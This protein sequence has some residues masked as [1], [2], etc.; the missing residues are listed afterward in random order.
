[1]AQRLKD[2]GLPEETENSIKQKLKHGTFPATFLLATLAAL[3]KDNL[4]LEDV[5]RPAHEALGQSRDHS[6]DYGWHCA[7]PLCRGGLSY[8][9]EHCGEIP[10]QRASGPK[11]KPQAPIFAQTGEDRGDEEDE[12]NKRYPVACG[13]IGFGPSVIGYLDHHEGFF[14]GIFTAALFFATFF[15]WRSTRD[16]TALTLE[17]SKL[18]REEFIASHRPRI[19]VRHIWIRDSLQED[20][21]ITA[22]LVF[23]NVGDTTALITSVTC[24]FKIVRIGDPLPEKIAALEGVWKLT[25]PDELDPG[26]AMTIAQISSSEVFSKQDIQNIRG[27]TVGLFCFGRICYSDIGPEK[28]RKFRTTAFCRAFSH[29]ALGSQN[30]GRFWPMHKPDPDYEFED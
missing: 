24:D 29:A 12:Y 16:L 30:V 13:V 28:T 8:Q 17:S 6:R 10:S 4:S 19:R 15:L 9:V 1:M 14:V 26:V 25:F 27:Q 11:D 20:R 21:R 23:T 3:G 22:D 5:R 7:L 18:A 2:H